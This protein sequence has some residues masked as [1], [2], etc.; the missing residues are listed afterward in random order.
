MKKTILTILTLILTVT[1]GVHVADALGTLTVPANPGTATQ[2][3][4]N[5]IYTK[6]TT[7]VATS[8]KTGLFTIPG[9]VAASFHTLTELYN[10]IPGTLTLSASTTTVP[11]GINNSTTTL[12]A[13]DTDLTAGNIKSGVNVFGV[14]GTLA[15]G[16]GSPSLTWQTNPS[17]SLCWD[18]NQGCS[19][20]SGVLDPAGDGSILLGA[21]EYCQN[22]ESDGVT[23]TT[24]PQNIWHLPTYHEFASITDTSV[25]NN[26]TQ[27]PGFAQSDLYW[28]STESSSDGPSNAWYW[29]TYGGS[30]NDGGKGNQGQ[31]RCV[32]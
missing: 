15:S 25:Y 23:A 17:L 12:D 27:V 24:T 5:D 22:L 30:I 3:T 6:L 29:D 2:Y 8:T 9:T 18:A 26:A 28:S 13:I 19:V 16:G 14:V 1:L 7:G 20:G 32:H 21:V 4:L 10:A 11:V 31:V